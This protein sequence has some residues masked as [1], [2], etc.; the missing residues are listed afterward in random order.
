[1]AL[2]TNAMA[3]VDVCNETGL[4]TGFTHNRRDL[5]ISGYADLFFHP[6][7]RY[8]ASESSNGMDLR[9]EAD[10]NPGGRDELF[11]TARFKSKQKD[12]KY[13]GQ[14]E[15]C[16]TGHYRLRWTHNCLNGTE[17]KTQ[18]FYVRYDFIAEPVSNGYAL[19][20]SFSNSLLKDKLNLNFTLAAFFTDSYD[21]RVSV[22]ESGLRFAYNFTSLYGKGMRL[23]ATIKYKI[24]DGIQINLKA[25]GTWYLDREEIGSAQQLI[26]SC[27]KEDIS[28]QLIG[29]F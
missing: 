4:L 1:M 26:H 2:H 10:W 15:Y 12:C 6:E 23:A 8:G 20:Q 7:P 17:L 3:E 18:L 24:K 21:S 27:H 29:K 25:G 28:V 5:K 16:L 22:Y 13:T 11:A 14:L 19:T 9:V